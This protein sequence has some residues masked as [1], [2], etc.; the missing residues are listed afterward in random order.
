MGDMNFADALHGNESGGAKEGE[1]H[2]DSGD[3]LGFAMAL[4][5]VVVGGKSGDF[6]S[7]PDNEGADKKAAM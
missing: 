4:R 3:R 1:R 5:T 2:D 6:E 7:G